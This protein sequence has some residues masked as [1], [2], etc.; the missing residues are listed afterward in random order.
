M[1]EMNI[2]LRQQQQSQEPVIEQFRKKLI[3]MEEKYKAAE[4]KKTS[5]MFEHEK[6]R[7]KW[8]LEKNHLQL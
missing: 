3:Q 2:K 6:E 8:Q 4:S 5:I 7:A 1:Q